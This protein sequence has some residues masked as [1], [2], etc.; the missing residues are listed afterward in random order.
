VALAKNV[1]V[2]N[3]IQQCGCDVLVWRWRWRLARSAPPL[4]MFLILRK[5]HTEQMSYVKFP[6]WRWCA[7]NIQQCG[8]DVP[9]FSIF[10]VV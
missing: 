6:S 1:E 8:C 2:R 7:P 4:V 3:S 10:L 5:F 9:P